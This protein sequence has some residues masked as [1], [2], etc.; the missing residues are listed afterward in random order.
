MSINDRVRDDA[1]DGFLNRT[2]YNGGMTQQD[3]KTAVALKSFRDEETKKEKKKRDEKF[4][5]MLKNNEK[6]KEEKTKK[7]EFLKNMEQMAMIA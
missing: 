2:N 5:R 7:Q 1:I 3:K 6:K 4:K